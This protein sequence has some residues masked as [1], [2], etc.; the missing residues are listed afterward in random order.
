MSASKPEKADVD[1]ERIETLY[2]T[3]AASLREIAADHG[4]SEGAIRKRA[5]RDEWVRD[6]ADKVRSKADSLVRKDLVRGEV[7]T[8][9]QSEKQA[10]D[11][12][13]Q[14]QARIRISHRSDIGRYRALCMSLLS[15]LEAQTG[16][17]SALVQL[18]E[19]LRS[20]N[21][22]GVDKLNDIYRAVIGLPERTKTMK[23]LAE[24]LKV[25]IGLE[26]EAFGIEATPQKI[27]HSGS[28]ESHMTIEFVDAGTVPK[29]P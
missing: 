21:D 15:E 28:V 12:E 25:L 22:N 19:M 17:V 3:N 10:V 5:K 18:G 14:V 8:D 2:R 16:D 13:A 24:S 26:R 11:V 4:I 23:A 29:S 7:R 27:E 1:W 6:L 20:E 9:P